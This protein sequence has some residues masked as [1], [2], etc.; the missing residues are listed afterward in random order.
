MPTGQK[1]Q[2]I[3]ETRKAAQML[4]QCEVMGEQYTAGDLGNVLVDGDFSGVNA[5]ITKAEFVAFYGTPLTDVLALLGK[6][7]MKTALYA[8]AQTGEAV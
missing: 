1:E 8:L 4:L 3:A 7:G 5:G 6:A 2:I